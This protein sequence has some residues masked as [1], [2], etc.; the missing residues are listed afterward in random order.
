MK[1]DKR[2]AAKSLKSRD[3]GSAHSRADEHGQPC[4]RRM[5]VRVSMGNRAPRDGWW[6]GRAADCASF[7]GLQHGFAALCTVMR[8][9]IRFRLLS[10]GF[11]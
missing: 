8:A 2:I 10:Q 3:A 5:V 9:C 11:V 7:Q 1:D 6:H 4:T